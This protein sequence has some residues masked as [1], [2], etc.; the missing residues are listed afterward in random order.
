MS[1]VPLRSD[2]S[3]VA[4]DAA[5]RITTAGVAVASRDTTVALA[6]N[7]LCATGYQSAISDAAAL[8]TVSTN[9]TSFADVGNGTSTGFSSWTTPAVPIPK[10]YLVWCRL[11][12]Y[13][14]TGGGG[15][16]FQMLVDGVAPA[17]Q[18]STA[19]RIF[20]NTTFQQFPM[21]FAVPV[22]LS[23]AT[24]VIK[25]Q[26]KV[27]SPAVAQVDANDGRTFWITG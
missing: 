20:A 12:C 1:Y 27:S 22:A 7:L 11:S 15:V 26:W 13:V 4:A 14:T 17:G 24:H 19:Q 8:G 2:A 10:T 18:P 16:F 5:S 9:S 23:A 25:L 3:A 6:D 21:F